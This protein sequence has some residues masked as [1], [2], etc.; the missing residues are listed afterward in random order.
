MHCT[1]GIC[2]GGEGG[3]RL[4]VVSGCVG[5][6]KKP[7]IMLEGTGGLKAVKMVLAALLVKTTVSAWRDFFRGENPVRPAYEKPD[8]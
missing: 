1:A 6:T 7:C 5:I 2:G 8:C 4:S 3:R